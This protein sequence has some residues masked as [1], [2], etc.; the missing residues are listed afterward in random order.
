MIFDFEAKT[1]Y[2]EKTVFLKKKSY[3][4]YMMEIQGK[5]IWFDLT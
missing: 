3:I 4:K 2:F 5:S 1:N